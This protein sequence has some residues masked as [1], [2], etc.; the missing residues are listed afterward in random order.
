MTLTYAHA[1]LIGVGSYVPEPVVTN[2]HL[3]SRYDTSADDGWEGEDHLD[4]YGRPQQFDQPATMSWSSALAL[5]WP[6]SRAM[7]ALNPPTAATV[8]KVRFLIIAP[9]KS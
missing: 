7:A 1:L 9:P 5:G 3:H 2:A 6:E 8:P 4:R